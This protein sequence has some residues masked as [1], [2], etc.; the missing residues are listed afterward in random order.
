MFRIC[1]NKAGTGKRRLPFKTLFVPQLAVLMLLAG[2][3]V[4]AKG[5]SQPVTMHEKN[6]SLEKVFELLQAQTGYHFMFN[7]HMLSQ[8]HPV[9]INAVNASVEE[10]LDQCFRSQPFTYVIQDKTIVVKAKEEKKAAVVNAAYTP[11]PLHI[12]GTVTDDKRAPV[13]G[14]S[15][16]IRALGKTVVSGREG[17]FDLVV[18]GAGSYVLEVSFVGYKPAQQTVEV[19]NESVTGISLVLQPANT[20]LTDVVVVGYGT[21]AKKNVTGSISSVKGDDFKNLPVSNAASAIDGRAA[22]VNIVQ[23][24]GAPGSVPS[25]RVLG[26]GTLN[27]ADPLVVID[28]V[29]TVSGLSDIN[30]NDIATIDILKDASSSAIYGSR[31]ANGVVII[32]TKKGNFGDQFSVDAGVYT[33]RNKPVKFLNMLTAPDLVKLKTEAYTNDG[34]PV[35]GVWSN[36]YYAV[37]RTDWQRA[38]IGTGTVNNADVAV[39]GGNAHSAYSF[40]GNYY[41]EK[42]MIVNSYFRRYSFRINSEHKIGGRIRVGENIVYAN[43]DGASPDTRSTQTGLV[44]SAIRFNPAIPVKNP[45]GTYG[46]SQADNQLGDIN[47][48]VATANEIQKYNKNDR[49]LANA[50][51]ELEI[52]KGLKLRANY[53]FDQT[54]NDYYEF[55]NAMPNQTR[56][57]S[58]ATLNRTHNKNMSFL[59][60]Y[61]LT[62]NGVLGGVHTLGVTAGYSAQTFKGNYFGATRTGF[63]DTSVDQRVLSLGNSDG[64]ANNGNN[65]PSA[66]L[67]SVFVRANY[68]YKNRYLLTATMRADG[69]S[70]FPKNKRWGYFPAF[71]LGWRVSDESFFTGG[72]K[73]VFNSVKITGGYGQL[74][75]QNIG[76]FQYLSTIGYG[77]GGG[78]GGGGY[79]YSLGTGTVYQNGAYVTG[80]ANPNITWERAVMSNISLDLAALHNHLT[81]TITYFNKNTSDM[82]IPYQLV[83]TFGAQNNLPDNPGNI[84]LPNVNLGRM[85]NHG[86]EIELGYQ[87]TLNKLHYNIG[88]NASF[89]SNKVTRLYG[90][91]TYIASTPYGRENADISR[92][93]EGQPIASFFG[94]RTAGLYQNQAAIDNDPYIKNDGNKANIKPGDV[95]FVDINGDGV[96]DDK[97][98]VRL[99]DPNPRFV[100]GFNGSASYRHFDFSFNFSGVLGMK[101]YN[102]DRLAGLDATQVY[103]WYADQLNRWHGEGTSNSVPRLSVS[104]LNNNYRSSDLWVQN[105][106]YLSLRNVSLGYT[107]SKQHIGSVQLPGIRVYVSSYNVFTI[108]KYQGYTP[109]LGYTN[110]VPPPNGSAPPSGNLQ[111]G[112]DVAQY[113]TARNF[114]IGASVN[115]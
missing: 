103:N 2:L 99:G 35:P 115:F 70:K 46:S 64:Q 104:N 94:F 34:L 58:V 15:V 63:A 80:L 40:S 18:P 17:K 29:P 60:E 89:I 78:N 27:N 12:T 69:S 52:V 24:D 55:D 96:I 47:N 106:A 23:S 28:G 57:P 92:T 7:T 54:L 110:S 25:I 112:V 16:S 26:T 67:Q 14:A 53:G 31:A 43:T 111:R 82:L 44:W 48:P 41:D 33:G 62:Y 68:A 91:S 36:P 102:A 50:F 86:V 11:P 97:D 98:R 90:N 83:E 6:I 5:L 85:N 30:P 93:Y 42:G 22:G 88:A 20:A 51:A 21:Q 8:G 107:F 113:P 81:A 87:N 100:F 114:T 72:I 37:Q 49:V 105:G 59:E 61:Y 66:G 32:T 3:H 45:D 109:M 38:L 73:R 13:E 71:S 84:T 4:A 56:G 19:D 95:R 74:G 108:T 9:S 76:D 65:N 10:V 101:L 75:N 79:G 77:G 39:R 1:S